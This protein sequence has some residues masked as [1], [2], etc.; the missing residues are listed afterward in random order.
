MKENILMTEDVQE[1]MQNMFQSDCNIISN[2]LSLTKV[3]TF[4]NNPDPKCDPKSPV[5]DC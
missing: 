1:S 5:M 3:I 2:S 4:F